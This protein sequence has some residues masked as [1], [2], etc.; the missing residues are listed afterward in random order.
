MMTRRTAGT[1]TANSNNKGPGSAQQT[2]RNK[3]QGRPGTGMPS[4]TQLTLFPSLAPSHCT[5][6]L[7]VRSAAEDRRA[8]TPALPGRKK[9]GGRP[10]ATH[11]HAA[12][13]SM[14]DGSDVEVP[15]PATASQDR[16]PPAVTR[17]HKQSQVSS[18]PTPARRSVPTSHRVVPDD[19]D[20]EDAIEEDTTE[21]GQEDEDEDDIYGGID[22]AVGDA[23][24]NEVRQ[25][26]HWH[27]FQL[28]IS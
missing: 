22:G 4:N 23:L 9:T 5:F 15:G 14:D 25:L 10:P 24:E 21:P 27:V 1:P 7:A 19:S 8:S 16:N 3:V 11:V 17:V 18:K 28:Y 12:P 2:N 6:F 20:E 13:A 26:S